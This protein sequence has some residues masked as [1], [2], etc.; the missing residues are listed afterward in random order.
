MMNI[1]R[2]R[3][4]NFVQAAHHAGSRVHGAG[5]GIGADTARAAVEGDG[6]DLEAV[7]VVE[8]AADGGFGVAGVAVAQNEVAGCAVC[9]AFGE[10]VVENLEAIRPADID[11]EIQVR[12]TS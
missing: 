5:N 10:V 11:L 12:D 8:I 6:N 4:G 7:N 1:L 2:Q 9:D 3:G